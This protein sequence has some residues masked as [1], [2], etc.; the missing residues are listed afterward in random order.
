MAQGYCDVCGKRAEY[1]AQVRRGG[2]R[3]VV[4]L[5]QEHY[6]Q[7][8]MRRQSTSPMDLLFGDQMFSSDPAG[9]SDLAR[10]MAAREGM[11]TKGPGFG[12][13]EAV[14]LESYLT[15]EAREALQAA[16]Q[17]VDE[18]GASV[19]DTEH[20]LYVLANTPSVKDILRRFKLN[21]SDLKQHIEHNFFESAGKPSEDTDN[22]KSMT[23][24]PRVKAA[25]QSAFRISREFGNTYIGP[26]HMFLGLM[27]IGDGRYAADHFLSHFIDIQPFGR[28]LEQYVCTAANQ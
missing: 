21:A 17:I 15:D 1:R 4:E 8:A 23:V 14:D 6:E 25:L 16:A 7:L 22:D 20:L 12:D 18:Q 13:R 5:C 9:L 2:R 24:S 10:A 26:A 19:I 11:D 28:T 27:D 3:V